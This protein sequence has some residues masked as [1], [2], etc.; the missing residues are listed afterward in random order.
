MKFVVQHVPGE[1]KHLLSAILGILPDTLV[2]ECRGNPME[3]FKRS[4]ISDAHWHFEDDIILAPDFADRSKRLVNDHP[5]MVIRAFGIDNKNGLMPASTY[6][7]NQAVFLPQGYGDMIAKFID[8]WQRIS[9]HPTGF[10]LVI[11]DW[12]V[13]RREKYW[14]ESPSLVQHA[15]VKSL[16]GARSTKRQSKSFAERYGR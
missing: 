13:S 11:R 10:D 3:T 6:L 5:N 16:L 9:E 8:K 15:Q 4:L 2:V 14:L 1:R 12:L 7:F